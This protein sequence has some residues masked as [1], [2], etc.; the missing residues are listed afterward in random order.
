MKKLTIA[1]CVLSLFASAGIF[2]Q[3]MGAGGKGHGGPMMGGRPCMSDDERGFTSSAP[4]RQANEMK[5][6]LGLTDEQTAK[7][8]EIEKMFEKERLEIREK[9]APKRFEL[10]KIL[11]ENSVDLKAVEKVLRAE[12]DL[13]VQ[14]RLSCIKE[15]IE[16]DSVLTPEQKQKMKSIVPRHKKQKEEGRPSR[17]E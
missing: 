4:C 13:K 10:E 15:K 11:I 8:A 1:L 5:K 9:L 12:S 7:I 3:E 2:A 6:D 14:M 16:V 17:H